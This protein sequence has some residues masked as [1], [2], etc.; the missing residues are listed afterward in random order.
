M[1]SNLCT[2]SPS[3]VVGVNQSHMTAISCGYSSVPVKFTMIP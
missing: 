1:C 3:V 2:S